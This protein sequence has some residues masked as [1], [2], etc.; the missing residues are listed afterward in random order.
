MLASKSEY[1]QEAS[2]TVY[3]MTSDRE[4]RERCQAREDYLF[5]ERIKNNK[6]A[7]ELAER[8][9]ALREKDS[10]IQNQGEELRNRD[11]VIQNQ[12]KELRNK[13]SVI[14]NQEEELARLRAE[15]E[16]LKSGSR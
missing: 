7:K 6:H 15:L 14:Q 5:W 13:D 1:L 3:K 2:N 10:V 8:D 16:A 11:S 4:I 9:A 12:G